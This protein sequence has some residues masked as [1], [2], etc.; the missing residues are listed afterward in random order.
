MAN[1]VPAS[2]SALPK[3]ALALLLIG[4]FLVL[5]VPYYR[6]VS[7]PAVGLFHDDGIYTVT[8]RSLAEGHGYLLINLP[9]EPPQTKYPPAFPLLLAA[10]WKLFPAFPENV[11][12]LKMVPLF[13]ALAWLT[14][15]W[16]LLRLLETPAPIA[17]A[18]CFAV[19]ASPYT[20][21]LS[22]ALLSETMFATFVTA[23]LA[24][25][26]RAT[27]H[28]VVSARHVALAGVFVAA[29]MLTRAIGITAVA[30][31]AVWLIFRKDW[32]L[33]C[34]FIVV[35]GALLSPWAWWVLQHRG[36]GYY[37]VDNYAS[38]HLFSTE[39]VPTVSHRIRV[40][41]ANLLMFVQSPNL[42]WSFP[43][44]LSPVTMLLGF[45]ILLAGF[46]RS[47]RQNSVTSWFALAYFGLLQCWLWPPL[48]FVVTVLPVFV[49]IALQAIPR[50]WLTARITPFAVAAMILM[51][52]VPAVVDSWQRGEAATNSGFFA[53]LPNT[54]ESWTELQDTAAWIRRHTTEDT[55]L[56]SNLD[57][58]FHLYTGR[59]A[60]R[61]FTIDPY[62][63]FYEI[64]PPA[65]A[66]QAYFSV[67]IAQFAQA[68]VAI[69]QSPDKSFSE[70]TLLH[71]EIAREVERGALRE[72]HQTGGVSVL[73]PVR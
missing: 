15:S 30:A 55:I 31:L 6:A 33:V 52:S 70:R 17:V 56:I 35:V 51:L 14:A 71:A 66:L 61:G 50:R 23:A 54:G 22:T 42:I 13:W 62:Q 27:R 45:G 2:G 11:F 34:V 44:G 46:T 7:T 39:V 26:E 49:W 63:M 1:K 18:V 59:K 57:P 24:L 48:R 47:L 20:V 64:D 69:I 53:W 4:L 40:L 8:A 25:L 21:Y 29:A 5:A 43:E 72:V 73:R 10:V 60:L 68:P 36:E 41:L 38:W 19:A 58:L 32:K 3:A 67:P 12:W 37:S 65:G 16:Y 28:G 9:G